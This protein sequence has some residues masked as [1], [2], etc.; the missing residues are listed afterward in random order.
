M[1]CIKEE[2]PISAHLPGDIKSDQVEMGPNYNTQVF[3]NL[4]HNHSVSENYETEWDIA[5]ECSDSGSHVILNSSTFCKVYKTTITNF[6]DS[7]SLTGISIE[8]WLYDVPSG[9]LDSTALV[10]YNNGNI[11]IIDMGVSVSAGGN[12]RGY[13]KILIENI[14]NNQY[15]IRYANLDGSLD[16]TKTIT[17]N[18]EINFIAY[19][20]ITNS[21]V[22]VFPNKNNWDLMFTAYTHIFNVN[23][24]ITPYRVA[25]VLI[26]RNN[27]SVAEDTIYDFNEI[28]YDLVIDNISFIYNKNIDVIGYDWKPYNGTFTIRENLNYIIKTNSGL[29]FK[30]RFID[31]Y[32]DNGIKGSPKFEFQKL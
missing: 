21:T 28:N 10:D 11:Y 12:P 9:N 6:N 2:L 1:S 17:K 30:L 7:I 31:F 19:S 16:V 24:T 14:S 4:K 25:G 5:F 13:K 15:Q 27:T 18:D 23:G 22:E 26:N 3:Y 20:F 29:Y 8:D 32:S